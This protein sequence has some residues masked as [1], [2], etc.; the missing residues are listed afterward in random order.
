[1]DWLRATIFGPQRRRWP[2]LGL[3]L[4]VLLLFFRAHFL[5]SLTVGDSMLPGLNSGDLLLVAR[6]AYRVEPPRRGEVVI[7]RQ[8]AGLI[9]KRIVGLPGEEVEVREGMVYINQAPIQE[10]H[11]IKPG[12]LEIKPGKLGPGKYALLGDNRSLLL[13]HQFHAVVSRDQ[14]VGK[15]VGRL[16]LPW[17]TMAKPYACTRDESDG[18]SGFQARLAGTG[19]EESGDSRRE[20]TW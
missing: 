14:L 11:P 18:A 1:M 2:A 20:R 17:R 19:P 12:V 6:R 7:A 8:R 3:G 16:K 13:T 15:V 5:L 4:A 10:S 9:V